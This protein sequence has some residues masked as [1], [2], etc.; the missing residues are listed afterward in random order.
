MRLGPALK[1]QRP[2]RV[3]RRNSVSVTR[4]PQLGG[5][6]M[7]QALLTGSLKGDDLGCAGL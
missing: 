3:P 7:K 4:P 5:E 2:R 1:L 6:V